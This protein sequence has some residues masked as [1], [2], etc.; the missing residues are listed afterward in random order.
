MKSKMPLKLFFLNFINRFSF[1]KENE[2]GN[3]NS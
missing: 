3:P 1:Y 2:G